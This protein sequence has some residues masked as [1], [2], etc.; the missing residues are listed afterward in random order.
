MTKEFCFLCFI[1]FISIIYNDFIIPYLLIYINKKLYDNIVIS[2]VI[3]TQ[4]DN[5]YLY[6][7]NQIKTRDINYENLNLILS[8]ISRK[9]EEFIKKKH[10]K[11]HT[12]MTKSCNDLKNDL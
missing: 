12:R 7:D 10:I 11:Y 9:Q 5:Y 2:Y 4:I 6:L 3:L 1:F 8:N